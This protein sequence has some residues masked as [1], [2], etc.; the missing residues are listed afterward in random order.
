MG[1]KPKGL[2]GSIWAFGAPGDGPN[3]PSGSKD[4][5]RRVLRELPNRS[6]GTPLREYVSPWA[7]WLGR[8]WALRDASKIGKRQK[9]PRAQ[10]KSNLFF[11]TR[12][13]QNDEE[14]LGPAVC[15]S[16]RRGPPFCF[17]EK[18]DIGAG[19]HNLTF[20]GL[21]VDPKTSKK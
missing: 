1:P 17:T 10:N 14:V 4:T 18:V 11:T 19:G 21:F 6:E 16:S 7:R 8:G 13:H 3:G 15:M 9:G 2:S 5:S 20:L 12:V